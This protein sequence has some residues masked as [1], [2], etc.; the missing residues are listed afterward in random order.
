MQQH[1]KHAQPVP[2]Y[3]SEDTDYMTIFAYLVQG[4]L[5]H[6]KTDE[7]LSTRGQG[8]LELVQELVEH[9]KVIVDVIDAFW[10]VANGQFSWDGPVEY[11]VV[12]TEIADYF[13]NYMAENGGNVPNGSELE[14]EVKRVMYIWCEILDNPDGYEPAAPDL[15][16]HVE[17]PKALCLSTSHLSRMDV[18]RLQEISKT[19]NYVWERESGI[20]LKLFPEFELGELCLSDGAEH[21]LRNCMQQ[22]YFIIEFDSDAAVFPGLR[23]YNW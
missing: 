1:K 5:S 12:E 20:V 10:I 3:T 23:T 22:D 6:E 21:L 15:S 17:Q 16:Q 18:S 9:A 2:R 11:E 7:A 13:A 4:V 14:K 8:Q 19:S